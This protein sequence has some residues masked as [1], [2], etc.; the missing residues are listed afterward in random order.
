M[1]K[2]TKIL[3]IT[4]MII[5]ISL[6]TSQLLQAPS[7]SQP[8]DSQLQS[9]LDD[10]P[11]K[12]DLE[13]VIEEAQAEN[14]EPENQITEEIRKTVKQVVE[15]ALGIFLKNDLRIV[16]IGDSLT[17]GVGDT[18][19]NG[20]YVGILKNTFKDNDQSI[21]I[22]NYG[23]RGNRSDQLLK[24]LENPEI[25][26]SIEKSDIVLVTI[27]AND[28]MK[29]VKD[30]FTD[31]KYDQFVEEQSNYSDRLT[32]IFDTI[33]D[34]NPDAS[35]FLIGFYNPFEKYFGDIEQL[36]LI[37]DNWNTAGNTISSEYD[38]IQFIP[39]ID[40][41]RDTEENLFSDDNF[42]PNIKGYQLIA[43]RV[44]KHIRPSI[45]RIEEDNTS[46]EQVEE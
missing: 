34:I 26:S 8:N 7:T 5:A 13:E 18:T 46:N 24:R 29:V 44:F 41:F 40:L 11:S 25:I 3:L 19:D 43:E 39:I 20:G 12:E 42:H 35:I 33:I 27:G 30:N 4:A 38:Q 23:K 9:A 32:K 36:G 28:I 31:I 15:S 22:D 17:Q 1:R 2:K 45:E 10:E 14:E 6:L 21:H 37:L 16:A